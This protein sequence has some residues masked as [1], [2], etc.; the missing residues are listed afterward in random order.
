MRVLVADRS[1]GAD[2][3]LE[4]ISGRGVGA[5]LR[6]PHRRSNRAAVAA[7]AAGAA[8]LAVDFFKDTD[9]LCGNWKADQR[10]EPKMDEAS[11]QRLYH[12][13]KKAVTRSF[14]WVE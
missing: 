12:F 2:L 4:V 6:A 13:W 10:W 14:D 9:E 11:R 7:Q 3:V 5:S 1:A 8:G